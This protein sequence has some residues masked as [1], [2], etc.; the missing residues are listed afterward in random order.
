MRRSPEGAEES[1]RL[2]QAPLFYGNRRLDL[3]AEPVPD[4]EACKALP[5]RG[6]IPILEVLAEHPELIDAF[7]GD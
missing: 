6:R 7:S 5:P 2:Q 3:T 4:L 1:I